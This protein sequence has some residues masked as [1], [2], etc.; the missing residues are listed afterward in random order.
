MNAELMENRTRSSLRERGR[1]LRDD[2]A[3]PPERSPRRID[4]SQLPDEFTPE[5]LRAMGIRTAH[6]LSRHDNGVLT[7]DEQVAFDRAL[8]QTLQQS[9]DRLGRSVG[10]ARRAAPETSDPELRSSYLRTQM[11]L[12]EQAKRARRTFPQLTEQWEPDDTAGEDAEATAVA[13]EPP[14]DDAESG[15][16]VS[17]ATFESELEQTADTLELLEQIAKIQQQQLEHQRSQLLS[18]TRGIFFAL[19]VS[20]A[21][22][23][24]GIAPLVEASGHDRALILGWTAVVCVVAGLG[25][26]AVR[27]FQSRS[28]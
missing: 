28:Q 9:T 7:R 10:R 6:A 15:D 11:R 14:G 13:V 25:Y 4:R 16:D 24:A 12:A 17:I 1:R 8:R 5:T 22:I 2:A 27:A 3:V 23:V 19:A 20:V 18:E 21:V 26:A